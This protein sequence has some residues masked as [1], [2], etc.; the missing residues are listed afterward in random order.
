M[1]SAI[2]ARQ[3]RCFAPGMLALMTLTILLA[4]TEPAHAIPVFARKYQ[5]ACATCHA[6]FPKLNGV[7]LAFKM[8]GYR[9]SQDDEDKVKQPPLQLGNDSYRDIF[10][11][12]I[13]PSSIPQFPPIAFELQQLMTTNMANA[14]GVPASGPSPDFNFPTQV[15]LLSGGTLTKNISF[16]AN[17]GLAQGGTGPGT[18][19]DPYVER[20]FLIVNNMFS[21]DQ[22]ED[23]NGMHLAPAG[24]VLPRHFLNLKVGQFDPYVIAPYASNYRSVTITAR[25]TDTLTV[26][27]NSFSFNNP[28]VRGVEGYGFFRNY[29]SWAFGVCDGGSTQQGPSGVDSHKD[30][31]ARLGHK[32]WGIPLDGEVV[33]T[34]KAQ[35]MRTTDVR[36]QNPDNACDLEEDDPTPWLDYYRQTQFE[37]GIFGYLGRNDV[38]PL[39]NPFLFTSG[40]TGMINQDNFDRVGADFQWQH[41]DLHILG[42]YIYGQDRDPGTGFALSF[43]SWFVEANYYFKPW[44]IGYARY[45]E[46]QFMQPGVTANNIQRGVPGVAFYP[47]LNLA[48]RT[49]FVIDASGK[50]TT[51]NQF[52]IMADYAF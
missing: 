29:T 35:P 44:I 37:T 5:T 6:G 43:N 34:R 30:M 7:G 8:N 23:E 40:T 42:T 26:G 17:G 50:G 1:R 41:Q 13:L 32:W 10:P 15:N 4:A 3:Q 20:A 9:F 16:W 24:L 31:Y 21:P 11:N 33:A 46:L 45:E 12:A 47:I 49:E 48:V 38:S 51:P 18:T 25:L 52:L 2:T 39:N 14:K 28:G 36:G 22:E 27:S 19:W